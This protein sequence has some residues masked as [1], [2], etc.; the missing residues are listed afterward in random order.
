MTPDSITA[1]VVHETAIDIKER[2][3]IHAYQDLLDFVTDFQ[4][5]RSGKPT[6]RMLA[7]IR[8]WDPQFNVQRASKEERIRWRR[9]YT[10]NWL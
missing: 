5:T 7:E 8:D 9:S 10:I 6:K 1:E 3:S 4:K 2:F